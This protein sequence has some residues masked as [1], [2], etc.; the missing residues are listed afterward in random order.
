MSDWK[1]VGMYL[2]MPHYPCS[3]LGGSR[4]PEYWS[5]HFGLEEI[6]WEKRKRWDNL[7]RQ[8]NQFCQSEQRAGRSLEVVESR[9]NHGWAGLRRDY[10]VFQ[11]VVI[12][13]HGRDIFESIVKQAKRAMKTVIN[14]QVLPEET[15]HTV[16]VETEAIVNSWPL[17]PVSDDPNDYEALTPNHVLIGQTSPNGPPGHFEECEINS[18]KRFRMAQA[19]ADMIWRRWHKEYLSTLTM[20]SKWNK[21]KRN[22][23]EEDLVLLK[24][25]DVPQSYWPLGWILEAFPRSDGR[26]CMAEVK[27]PNGTLMRPVTKLC[28]LEESVEEN[29]AELWPFKNFSLFVVVCSLRFS[30]TLLVHWGEGEALAIQIVVT[31]PIPG[32]LAGVKRTT[33]SICGRMLMLCL[34]KG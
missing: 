15:L 32:E 22:L 20:R 25:D 21:V 5:L 26:V 30:F 31:Y 2:H 8:W 10:L 4:Q 11:P 33:R 1:E 13:T 28:I 17:T 18:C 12:P 23:K 14:D 16:F 27:T 29:N 6:S 19:L 24:G 34:S 9:A 3:P 7:F